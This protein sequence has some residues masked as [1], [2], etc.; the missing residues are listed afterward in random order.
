MNYGDEADDDIDNEKLH[1]AVRKGNYVRC[2]DIVES[3]HE[4]LNKECNKKYALCLAC[5]QNNLDLVD[6]FIKV[7]NKSIIIYSKINESFSSYYC[8]YN[9]TKLM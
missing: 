1:E 9:R 8:M 4:L 7:S 6:L 3:K 5:E 2:R